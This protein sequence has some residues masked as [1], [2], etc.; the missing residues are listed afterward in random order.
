MALYQN[1]GGHSVREEGS[2]STENEIAFYNENQVAFVTHR[3]ITYGFL[4]LLYNADNVNGCTTLLGVR[5]RGDPINKIISADNAVLDKPEY[6][7]I[8]TDLLP[9]AYTPGT[10]IMPLSGINTRQIASIQNFLGQFPT[11]FMFPHQKTSSQI[12][13]PMLSVNSQSNRQSQQFPNTIQNGI[14]NQQIESST[15]VCQSG[16]LSTNEGSLI[17]GLSQMPV[18]IAERLEAAVN[19]SSVIEH[20]C[21]NA[22]EKDS[23]NILLLAN[24]E[25]KV[26]STTTID[27]HA[28]LAADTEPMEFPF[29]CDVCLIPFKSNSK[30]QSHK[31]RHTDDKPYLCS[32]CGETFECHT[33]LAKH[34][35]ELHLGCKTFKCKQCIKS[36]STRKELSQHTWRHTGIKMYKCGICDKYYTSA[37]NLAA[38][39]RRHKGIC[40]MKCSFCP[41]IFGHKSSLERHIRGSHTGER[42]FVCQSCSKSF[43]TS[44][45]LTSHAKK[46]SDVRPFKCSECGM[47]FRQKHVLQRHQKVH[48]NNKPYKCHVC[49]RCFRNAFN[50]Q[51]HTRTHIDKSSRCIPC[52][53]CNKKVTIGRGIKRHLKLYHSG[54][55]F[56]KAE[57]KILTRSLRKEGNKIAKEQG[58]G[59]AK[60]E[61]YNEHCEVAS[62]NKGRLNGGKEPKMGCD[63]TS[64][65]KNSPETGPN[66]I[67]KSLLSCAK[68]SQEKKDSG[69]QKE[70]AFTCNLCGKSFDKN[71]SLTR[72][73]KIHT[74]QRPYQCEICSK[75]FRASFN[76]DY[77]KRTHIGKADRCVACPFCK[78]KVV[79]GRGARRHLRLYHGINC[80]NEDAAKSVMKRTASRNELTDPVH[81]CVF[82]GDVQNTKAGFTKIQDYTSKQEPIF[83]LQN[84]I[85]PKEGDDIQRLHKNDKT[86]KL[87]ENLAEEPLVFGATFMAKSSTSNELDSNDVTNITLKDKLQRDMSSKGAECVLESQNALRSLKLLEKKSSF[88]KAVAFKGNQTDSEVDSRLDKEKTHRMKKKCLAVCCDKKRT[89]DNK[90]VKRSGLDCHLVL[91]QK[92]LSNTNTLGKGQKH[93]NEILEEHSFQILSRN[94]SDADDVKCEYHNNDVAME[95]SEGVTSYS[96]T[97]RSPA[98]ELLSNEVELPNESRLFKFEKFYNTRIPV[99]NHEITLR[100]S[101]NKVVESDFDQGIPPIVTIGAFDPNPPSG[102][103]YALMPVLLENEFMSQFKKK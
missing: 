72:H 14:G 98:E 70:K 25:A 63:V 18:S 22:Q 62:T 2:I 30:L 69:K 65:E 53:L 40:S 84:H 42:P 33:D 100:Y 35:E 24:D 57:G 31:R 71:H 29:S 32:Y 7:L 45:Q 67:D 50:L 55:C 75:T 80:S 10:S 66:K 34:R 20:E 58:I 51:C 8:T 56:S 19:S 21:E 81:Q 46:H 1:W 94:I 77:H 43:P 103:S 102:Y 73:L 41:E 88:R 39:Q 52:S 85:S 54:E 49:K 83:C 60:G 89:E 92:N 87:G 27:I 44:S 37:G 82:G 48:A 6:D 59:S 15:N 4:S 93:K 47:S 101:L 76:L 23:T 99:L 68:S 79:I 16:V 3:G 26:K 86:G 90:R 64:G 11:S 61:K 91:G 96:T 12:Q 28:K 38:H 78:K 97:S 5:P 95:D 9:Q 74:D 13:L 17:T 36:F